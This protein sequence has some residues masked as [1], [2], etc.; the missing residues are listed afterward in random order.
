M[1]SSEAVLDAAVAEAEVEVPG[2]L[3]HARAHEM[4]EQMMTTLARQGISKETYLQISGKDEESLAHEAEPE[5]AE[6]ARARGGA[7]GDRRG[8]EHRAERR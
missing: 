5:A 4:L 8:R 7:R 2:P 1:S 6:R 3:V